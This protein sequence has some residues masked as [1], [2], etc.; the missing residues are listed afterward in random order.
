MPGKAKEKRIYYLTLV[1]WRRLKPLPLPN[2]KMNSLQDIDVGVF[3]ARLLYEHDAVGLP[4]L[5]RFE[6]R[7]KPAEVDRVQGK[8]FPPSKRLVFLPG[9]GEGGDRLVVRIRDQ[10]GLSQETAERVVADFVTR[11]RGAVRQ[12]EIVVFPQLGRLYE[13]Y[14]HKLQ[15]I[16]DST[17]FNPSTFGLPALN[18][19]GSP[20]RTIIQRADPPAR[21]PAAI[22]RWDLL[23]AFFRRHLSLIG[24][25]LLFV[26]ALSIYLIL[27]KQP[28]A[29]EPTREERVIPPERLNQPPV[30]RNLPDVPEAT[31]ES[32]LDT[33][34]PELDTEAST[35]APDQQSAILAIGLFGDQE[36]I[37][38]LVRSIYQAGFEPYL[39]PKSNGLTLVGIQSAYQDEEDLQRLLEEV[40]T[41]FVPDAF[42]LRR[43]EN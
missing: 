20:S 10:Y 14:Q 16:P 5:G 42:V 19:Q 11:I 17:N 6:T 21:R 40:R 2:G 4:G 34:S 18:Y 33:P 8:L 39:E 3:L 29:P 7:Y 23:R 24:I 37:D 25:L 9:E 15:F 13:D 31:D 26:L 12:R 22:S 36:N 43:S 41:T 30:P 1:G 27:P 28:L 35:I 32:D 38:R